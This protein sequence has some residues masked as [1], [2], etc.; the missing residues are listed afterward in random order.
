MRPPTLLKSRDPWLDTLAPLFGN[1]L[2]DALEVQWTY[3]DSLR[4]FLNLHEIDIKDVEQ[5]K[6]DERTMTVFSYLTDEEGRR[7]VDGHEIARADPVTINY[8]IG[9]KI[10]DD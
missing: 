9:L 4:E 8:R 7:Y 2:D 1:T 10:F 3:R 6:F 5:I